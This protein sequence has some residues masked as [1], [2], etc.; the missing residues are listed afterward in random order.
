MKPRHK[1]VHRRHTILHSSSHLDRNRNIAEDIIHS[2]QTFAKFASHIEHYLGSQSRIIYG[3]C[4]GLQA[5]PLP[6]WNT[7]SIGQPALRSTKSMLSHS[8]PITSAHDAALT[9]ELDPVSHGLKST[10]TCSGLFP[11]ICT[12]KM[13]SEGCRL[14]NDHSSFEP[15]RNECDNPISPHVISTPRVE[16]N[17]RNGCIVDRLLKGGVEGGHTHQIAHCGERSKIWRIMVSSEW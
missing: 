4:I 17:R 1:F 14:T 6:A 3:L 7:K 8:F 16:H 15:C 13:R 9:F 11:A 12:P 5:L 2:H 10:R